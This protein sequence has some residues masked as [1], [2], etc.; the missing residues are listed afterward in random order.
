MY[1]LAADGK[2]IATLSE[3]TIKPFNGY[4]RLIQ[5]G[6]VDGKTIADG[7]TVA[8]LTFTAAGTPVFV[9]AKVIMPGATATRSSA[10]SPSPTT[11]HRVPPPDT[12]PIEVWVPVR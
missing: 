2:K 11:R 6:A 9:E 3:P 7:F 1:D 10:A 4:P 12:H 5:V 8:P